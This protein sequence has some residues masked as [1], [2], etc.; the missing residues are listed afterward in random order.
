MA[1]SVTTR[2]R[3]KSRLGS[4]PASTNMD[5]L[6]D[7][8]ILAVT[9]AFE[10]LLELPLTAAQQ[11]EVHSI[12]FAQSHLWLKTYFGKEMAVPTVSS[13]KVRSF[14]TTAWADVTAEASTSYALSTDKPGLLLYNG[15]FPEG[16]DTVQVVL[17]SSGFSDTTDNFITAY[18]AIADAADSQIVHEFKRR[19]DAGQYTESI[20]GGSATH[21]EVKLL[22]SVVDRLQPY[23]RVWFV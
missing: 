13:V 2:A 22:Q 10:R 21:R 16:V 1:V 18:P 6:I 20:N 23:R 11:T 9:D 7:G 3:V 4:T 14:F 17:A 12:G 15:H 19:D 8:L 5:S